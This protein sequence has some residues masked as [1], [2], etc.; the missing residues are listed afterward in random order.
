[1]VVNKVPNFPS[2]IYKYFA[3]NISQCINPT[4]FEHVKTKQIVQ[5]AWKL[6]NYCNV[7]PQRNNLIKLTNYDETK[8]RGLDSETVRAKENPKLTHGGPSQTQAK[9]P[10][11]RLKLNVR[12]VIESEA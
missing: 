9:V 8:K 6:P 3:L 12:A 1:M 11:N 10:T 2:F 5:V 4:H 7:T